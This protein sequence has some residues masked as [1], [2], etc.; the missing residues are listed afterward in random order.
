MAKSE[1]QINILLIRV[2]E[3]SENAGLKLNV[4]KTKIPSLR[5]K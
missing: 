1:K 5:G 3:D 4:Q 2:K